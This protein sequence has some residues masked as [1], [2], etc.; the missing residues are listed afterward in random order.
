[1]ELQPFEIF[2]GI[3]EIIFV[4]ITMVL[5]FSIIA[6]YFASKNRE[7]LLVGLTWIIMT[8]PWIAGIYSFLFTLFTGNMITTEA[9]LIVGFTFL[10]VAMLLWIIV[11][12]DLV[13]KE[14]QKIIVAIVL[15]YSVIFETFFFYYLFTQPSILAVLHRPLEIEYKLFIQ[16]YLIF[17]MTFTLLT[18]I[19]F[20]Q[21]T[22]QL[23]G[24]ELKWRGNLLIVAFVLL[25]IGA[26]FD[27]IFTQ[28]IL[29][30]LFKRLILIFA[31]F[32]FYCSFVIPKWLK[33]LILKDN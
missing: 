19:I 14:K 25:I 8:E 16:L 31:S 6:K 22:K 28:D 3:T 18:G 27:T 17:L 29:L 21:K 1:M 32:A 9:Y 33:N 23:G 4:G 2:N 30:I 15:I 12:T 5:G 24:A 11:F 7:L 20:A 10:S 13:Y 26:I